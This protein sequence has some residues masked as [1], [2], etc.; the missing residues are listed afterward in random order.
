MFVRVFLLR[1]WREPLWYRV[2]ESCAAGL[3]RGMCVRVPLRAEVIPAVVTDVSSILPKGLAFKLRDIIDIIS[4]TSDERFKSFAEKAARFY[5]REQHYF[6]RRIQHFLTA[7]VVDKGSSKLEVLSVEVEKKRPQ[8]T[9]AQLDAVEAIAPACESSKFYPTLLHGVT[10]SG[11]TEVYRRLIEITAK[12]GKS[13]IL[14]LPEV[15]LAMQFTSL[16]ARAFANKIPVFGFHSASKKSDRAAVFGAA[17]SGEPVIIIGVHLPIFLPIPN[18]GLIII[19]EEHEQGYQEKKHPRV[20]S[21]EMA[22]M[23]AK[24]YGIPIVLGSATPSIASL[25]GVNNG[26]LKCVKLPERFIGDF[27]EVIRVPLRHREKR[28]SFW[29]TNELDRLIKDRLEKKQQIILFLNRRG[30][31]FFVQCKSCG[32]SVV[33]PHCSV[34]LTP[35]RTRTATENSELRCHYCDYSRDIPNECCKC[36]ASGKDFKFKG[37]GTQQLITIIR[38]LYPEARAERADFDTASRKKEWVETIDKFSRGEIDILVGTQIVTKGYHFPNVTLV[39]V[40]W[41][42]LNLNMPIFNAREVAMQKLIQVAGRSGRS[43][44]KG[45]VVIQS[46]VDDPLFRSLDERDYVKFCN[47]ELEIRKNAWYPPFCRFVQ[48]ECRGDESQQVEQDADVAADLLEEI[49]EQQ[50]I[51]ISVFGPVKPAVHKVQ[52]VEIRHIFL[53]AATFDEVH[54]VL[55][56]FDFNNFSSQF[57]V[58]PTVG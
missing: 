26:T 57:F 28:R 9:P 48:I 31:C 30:H 13:T 46:M 51:A 44:K 17:Q 25:H 52:K 22:L 16:A 12:S 27:P 40:I 21:K 45:L 2:P 54:Q 11:K 50:K 18:L 8:L 34:T 19:D 6:F 49:S 3:A 53:K 5:F 35:H 4:L 33:C 32:E 10:G 47:R 20:N 7:D 14:L 39:G 24:I 43:L 42:D 55:R 29:I 41:A 56:H 23:R 15:S 37:I 1:G 38:D 58:T 36:S